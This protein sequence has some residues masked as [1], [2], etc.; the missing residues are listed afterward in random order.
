MK[1][2]KQERPVPGFSDTYPSA[3]EFQISLIRR[4]SISERISLALS[5]SQTIIQLSKRAILRANPDLNDEEL[6]LIF[7]EYHYG[8]K[9]ADRVRQYLKQKRCERI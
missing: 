2:E 6:G 8:S 5:L 3:E 1:R 9:L 4:A 7:I